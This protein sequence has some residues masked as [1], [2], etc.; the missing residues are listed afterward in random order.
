MNFTILTLTT[1]LVMV[2]AAS[3]HKTKEQLLDDIL[4]SASSLEKQVTKSK[5]FFCLAQ[6]ALVDAN[7]SSTNNVP[8]AERLIR[9]LKKLNEKSGNTNCTL[10]TTDK[11]PLS[12]LLIDISECTQLCKE[13]LI[14]CLNNS[15]SLRSRS[16][17]LRRSSS[18]L[19]DSCKSFSCSSALAKRSTP[20]TITFFSK[21]DNLS[22]KSS[23]LA[24]FLSS[25]SMSSLASNAFL[26]SSIF[27]CISTILSGETFFLP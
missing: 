19:L 16:A 3:L 17:L 10:N 5:G 15:D 1:M 9:Q 22:S 20:P 4:Q 8:D 26:S 24:L 11:Y 18:S 2:Y 7:V 12:D 21:A 14:Q 6:K 23:A 25:S 27:A 13:H